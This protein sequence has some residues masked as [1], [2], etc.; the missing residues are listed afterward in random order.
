MHSANDAPW[1]P[2]ESEQYFTLE[3]PG[4][5]W[6][7]DAQMMKVVPLCGRDKYVAG[8]GEMLI[9]MAGVFKVANERG[10]KSDQGATVLLAI[11]SG[12]G[13]VGAFVAVFGAFVAASKNAP[14]PFMNFQRSSAQTS[15][16]FSLGCTL[17]G[18]R[19]MSSCEAS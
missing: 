2:V 13:T 6:W 9:T 4:F 10:P 5:V 11:S 15:P 17:S 16:P 12:Q 19:A 14:S 18:R 1:M 7:M 3:D 8:E